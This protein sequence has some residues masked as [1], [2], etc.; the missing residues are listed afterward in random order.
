MT[1]RQPNNWLAALA[2]LLPL[3]SACLG[4]VTGSPVDHKLAQLRAAVEK[5][6][7]DAAAWRELGRHYYAWHRP[8][9]A[10]KAWRESL[11][12][13]P[14][15]AK[16]H[17]SIGTVYSDKDAAAAKAEYRAALAIDPDHG[18]SLLNLGNLYRHEGRF[19]DAERLLARAAKNDVSDSWS[20]GQLYAD[21][22]RWE[23]AEAAFVRSVGYEGWGLFGI[24]TLHADLGRARAKLGRDTEAIAALETALE[25]YR[26][27]G[28]HYWPLDDVCWNAGDRGPS[29]AWNAA[30]SR[31]MAELLYLQA[32]L[33][34]RSGDPQGALESLRGAVERLPE[35]REAARREADLKAVLPLLDDLMPRR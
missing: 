5:R 26:S 12:L 23:E 14:G 9:E 33:I 3:T 10:V 21:Q 30:D 8:D 11:R 24:A 4:Q 25:A 29:S 27:L 20:L 35:L 31:E 16:L 22:G 34:A 19:E 13:E 28:D 1:I 2:L 7:E 15:Q 32:R 18:G 17:W 6:P